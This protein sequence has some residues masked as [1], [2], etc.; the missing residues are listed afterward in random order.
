M[1]PQKGEAIT[2]THFQAL[3]IFSF[4]VSALLACLTKKDFFAWLR[5]TVW[6][7]AL[8]LAAGLAIA[9]VIYPFSH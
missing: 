5:T 9:W 4:L 2:L 6:Y 3:M 1:S 7:F 8:F